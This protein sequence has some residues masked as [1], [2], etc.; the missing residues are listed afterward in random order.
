MIRDYE[1]PSASLNKKA[2][3]GP[4]ISSGGKRGMLRPLDGHDINHP[5]EVHEPSMTHPMSFTKSL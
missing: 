1:N 2:L 4:A 5:G 3:L